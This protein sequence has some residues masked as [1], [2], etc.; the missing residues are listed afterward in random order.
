MM[1]RPSILTVFSSAVGSVRRVAMKP[2]ATQL[3]L[4]FMRPHS[5]A[6]VLVMPI[7]PALAAE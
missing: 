5:R 1:S 3:T 2:K 4:T 6:S 7:T